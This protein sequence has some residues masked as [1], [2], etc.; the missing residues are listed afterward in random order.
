MKLFVPLAILGLVTAPAADAQRRGDQ[1]RAYEGRRAGRL[2]PLPEIERRIVP[3]MRGAQYLGVDFDSDAVVYT[4]K[5]LRD[6]NVIWIE[7]DGQT[8]QVVGRSGR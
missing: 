4:L 5:F 1:A 7:V 3:T 2:L 8:G 6:G